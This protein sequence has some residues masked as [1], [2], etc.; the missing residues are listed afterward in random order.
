MQY[1]NRI[2][3]ALA[4]LAAA[5]CT[6]VKTTPGGE[7][8]RVLTADRV[9]T[10]VKLGDTTVS[11]MH[12]VAG[13]NRSQEKVRKELATL[14]RNSAAEIGGDTVVATSPVRDGQQTFDVYQCIGVGR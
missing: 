4:I 8:V 13:I 3:A 14:A 11:L 2:V 7:E 1:L 12:R 9:S 5:G 6:W 10:C